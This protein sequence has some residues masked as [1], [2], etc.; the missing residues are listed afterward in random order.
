MQQQR[1]LE[2][3]RIDLSGLE[4][5]EIETFLQDGSKGL[6]ELAASCSGICHY[7]CCAASCN[8][9]VVSGGD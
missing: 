8:V 5:G 6:P 1:E 3:L 4:I 2:P 7:L 9:Q